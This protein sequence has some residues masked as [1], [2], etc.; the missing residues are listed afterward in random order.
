MSSNS[1]TS[2]SDRRALVGFAGTALWFSVPVLAY[3]LIITIADPFRLFSGV[4]V[5]SDELKQ[6]TARPLN[7]CLWKLVYFDRHPAAHILLGDSRME[8]LPAAAVTVRTGQAYTNLAYGGATL[9][10]IIDTF[11]FAANRQPL[12]SVVIGMNLNVYNGYAIYRR[13]EAVE[14]FLT[15]R[16]LYFTNRNVAEAAYQ[17]YRAAAT[18]VVPDLDR[19]WAEKEAFWDGIVAVQ[20][21]EYRRWAEPAAYRMQLSKIAEWCRARDVKLTFVAF[22]SHQDIRAVMNKYGRMDALGA[23]KKDLSGWGRLVDFEQDSELTRDRTR[24]MDPVHV[25]RETGSLL[26]QEIFPGS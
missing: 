25:T 9:N 14:S 17:T 18:G 2:S 19:V 5:F 13:T 26:V 21:V 16:L 3:M 12:K 6:K 24:F 22:P 7:P 4:S 23:M 20:D 8:G 15:N 10:E 1:S 11:W